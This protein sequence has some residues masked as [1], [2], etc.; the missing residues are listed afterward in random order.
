MSYTK[1]M[2]L[3]KT[4]SLYLARGDMFNDNYEGIESLL[5]RNIR[6]VVHDSNSFKEN[7]RLYERNRRCVA[8]SCWYVGN[9]ESGDM[10]AKFAAG[11]DGIAIRTNVANLKNAIAAYG[12][13]VCVRKIEY[14]AD[15]D[16]EF[17]KFGCPFYPFSIKR[18]REF[19]EENELRVIWGEGKGCKAGSQ[20][21]KAPEIA[22]KF[23]RIDIDPS[24]LI[25]EVIVSPISPESFSNKLQQEMEN[26]KVETNVISSVLNVNEVKDDSFTT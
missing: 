15:H 10:W 21:Y 7:T 8:I 25:E 3:I 6:T 26:L 2:D 18:K 24:I 16:D 14:V 1:F 12:N 20:L 17:T 4:R 19:S 11:P 9:V 13:E 5:S 22:S 23:V